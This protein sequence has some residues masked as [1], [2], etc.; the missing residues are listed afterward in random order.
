MSAVTDGGLEL[1]RVSIVGHG[2][3][4]LNIVGGGPPLELGLRLHHDLNPANKRNTGF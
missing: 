2:D 1:G 3:H 4:D